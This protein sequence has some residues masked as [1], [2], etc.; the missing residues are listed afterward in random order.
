MSI[1]IR[2][3]VSRNDL[4]KFIFLPA[5]IH[6]NHE[7]WVP[8]VYM[9]DRIFFNPAKNNSFSHSDTVLYMAW[10]DGKPVG[11]IMGIINHH[12][13]ERTGENDARFSFLECYEDFA[14]AE[15][16]VTAIEKWAQS[17]GSDNLV[18][19][20]AFSDKDPQGL[21]IEGYDKPVVIASACNFPYL[22]GFV[23]RL[24]YS[25]KTD[26][27]DYQ[28]KVPDEFP[29]FYLKIYDRAM[30]NNPNLKI[31]EPKSK[32]ELKK[33]VRP[34]FHLI[35]ET[36]KHIYGFAEMTVQEMDEFADRYIMILDTKFIKVIKNSYDE[37]I[38]FVLAMP[39]VSE[40]IKKSK[41]FVFPLGFISILKSQKETKQLNL[42]L[43]AIEKN[44]RNAGLDTILGVLLLQEAVKAGFK[45]IDSHLMLETN[46]KIRAE[47]EKMGGKVYKRFRIFTKP[48]K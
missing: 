8:P 11:R 35:N 46:V 12:Y 47:M 38:A 23:E 25:K 43:G 32:K 40:G 20:L 33:L 14:V 27:V 28:L 31:V 26:L 17:K 7:N 36:Y 41:G 16:L 6:K 44:Y 30:R 10:V 48:M 39:D 15:A 42:L 2:E 37:V 9:D 21:L 19:P 3:V 4:K 1:E 22:V 34:V 13:N 29:D 45:N 5:E 18:G 24:G